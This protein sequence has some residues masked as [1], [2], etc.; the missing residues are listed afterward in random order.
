MTNETPSELQIARAR[1]VQMEAQL[2]A[3]HERYALVISGTNDGIWDWNRDT[4]EVYF[5]PRWKEIIGYADHE[6]PNEISVW[7]SRIH[8]EDF[9]RVMAANNRFK[10]SDASH[11]EVEYRIRHRDGSYRWVLGRGACLRDA[12]GHPYRLAGAHT[13]I[14]ARKEAEA[15]LRTSEAQKRA[16]LDGIAASLTF[17]DT[18][19]QIQWANRHAAKAVG[20]SPVGH[21][22]QA[23]W[24]QHPRIC[25]DCPTVRALRDKTPQYGI[26]QS[27]DGRIWDR[28]AEPVFDERGQMT[29]AVVIA[30]DITTVMHTQR[31]L[32]EARKASDQASK[33]KSEFLANMSHEIRT[34]LNGL[35][36]MLQLLLAS[37]SDPEQTELLDIALQSGKR[38]GILLTDIMDLSRIE[39]NKL[40]IQADAL[41]IPDIFRDA[42][43]LFRKA[44]ADRCLRVTSHV[45]PAVPAFIVSD[46]LRLRQVLFN[47]IGNAIKFT[48]RGEVSMEAYPLP[49]PS[50]DTAR[51]LFV[52]SDTGV[53]IPQ[54]KIRDIFEMFTQ[55]GLARDPERE[56]AGLGLA[57]VQKL[58][59]LMGGRIAVE[60]EPGQGSTFYVCLPFGL[61]ADIPDR[62][63]TDATDT[64]LMTRSVLIVDDDPINRLALRRMLERAS[65]HVCEAED[66]LRAVDMAAAEC[67]DLV[68][69][70]VQMPNLD[71][72]GATRAIRA[73]LDSPNAD[74]PII[75]LTAFA[76]DKDKT[77]CLQAG[78]NDYMT[79]PV[80]MR[81]V[82]TIIR[83]HGRSSTT[84]SP[85]PWI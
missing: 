82:E 5:S 48:L 70:D 10:Y 36:G 34:P 56:G 52:V 17:V 8:P 15:A 72:L 45:H 19:L 22:C 26:V 28:R 4:D 27:P 38:L 35:L 79:K 25:A 16:L 50:P 32:I 65:I 41:H 76:S 40:R 2:R 55:S 74:T 1:L 73:R 77:A 61:A 29:G 6:L 60:S 13:D 37:A 39:A 46:A 20:G 84:S 75:A 43:A 42:S 67:F 80:D 63:A 14:T 53:G 24:R 3:S 30:Q 47:L 58:V 64:A 23:L 51:V 33:A 12:S 49:S 85:L 66:G 78:M 68:F 54:D 59:D 69:M 44:A 7:T 18:T 62:E 21:T 71:G 9:N 57:I 11:F 81:A 83:R 31:E